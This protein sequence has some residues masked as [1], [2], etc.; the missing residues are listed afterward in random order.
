M[1]PRQRDI[2]R[3][4]AIAA[5][6]ALAAPASM[7]QTAPAAS[8]AAPARTYA[9]A[10]RNFGDSLLTYVGASLGATQFD[11]VC[12]TAAACDHSGVGGRLYAG[13]QFNR[14]LGL[15]VAYVN[16]G[17]PDGTGGGT[18]RS[19]GAGLSLVGI[20]PVGAIGE[21]NARLG[22]FYTRSQNSGILASTYGASAK[23]FG[24]AFGAGLGV[25]ITPNVQLR[26]DWD[27]HNLEIN[28]RD[29][30]VD[31]LAAGLRFRF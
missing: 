2:P 22:T 3:A 5:L 13:G 30:H 14:H 24:L 6:L 4:V 8:R 15:E 11:V 17:R 28:G 31:M 23:G 20:L 26:V 21:L 19:Q 10:E 29:T 12:P 18:R 25:D 1:P 9:Q 7:A 27:R 16:L